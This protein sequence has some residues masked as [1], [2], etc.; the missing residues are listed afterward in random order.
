M[1]Y[2]AL[3]LVGSWVVLAFSVGMVKG[4]LQLFLK[5][6]LMSS[7]FYG[8]LAW[9]IQSYQDKREAITDEHRTK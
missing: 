8:G 5:L 3:E 9:R 6:F 4:N 2:L 7:L 1:V